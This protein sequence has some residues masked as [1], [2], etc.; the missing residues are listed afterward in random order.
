MKFGFQIGTGASAPVPINHD[1]NSHCHVLLTGGSGAGKSYALLY[2]MGS[3]LQ[4]DP[5]IA[6]Y[7]C[8]FKNSED[9]E[10]LKGYPY[11]YAGD[12]VF[13]GIATYYQCL[14]ETRKTREYCRQHILI[15]DE[16]PAFIN[17]LTI[18]DKRD[19]SKKATEVMG[20]I[21][22]ILMM[23]RGIG[24]GVWIITQRADATLFTNGARDNF[25]IIIGLGRM[26]KEQ[27][28]MV[29]AGEDIPDRIYGLGEGVILADGQPIMEI[30]YPCI[31]NVY[32]WKKH[33]KLILMEHR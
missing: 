17:Y 33:I 26:S 4:S 25:M 24:Y 9:F 3:L 16:Y 2:L 11:Y 19:K 7:F 32:D 8:D 29:F 14:C 20:Y 12:D 27:K 31:K 23:G 13:D 28:G 1:I 6:V 18:I 15:I 21:A 10:F 5:N 30:K 22:E